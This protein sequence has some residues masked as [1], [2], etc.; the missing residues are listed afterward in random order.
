MAVGNYSY[1]ELLDQV[2]D[3]SR[4]SNITN[5]LTVRN[6]INRAARVVVSGVD[7]RGT[8]RNSALST[9][10]FD[11]IYQY[12]VP[13][14]IKG[15]AIIDIQPQVNRRSDFRLTLVDEAEFDLKK[16][17]R[18]DIVAI[19]RDELVNR[20]L[21][22]GN[23][24]DVTT[25]AATFDSL[26]ADGGTW[27]LFGD[28][29]NVTAEL[30]N[31]IAGSGSIEFDL[32]GSGTTAGISSTIT[33]IDVTDFVNAGHVFV[34]VYINSTTNLT[35]WILRIGSNAS[36]YFTQTVTTDH[37]S[38]SFVNGWNLLRFDFAS[39]TETGTVVRTAVVYAAIFMTKTSAKSD[40]GYRVDQMVLHTGEIHNL[41]YYS[42]FAWQNSSGTYLEDSTSDTDLLNAETDEIE[43]YVWR[44]KMELYRELRRSDLVTDA[45]E[46]Y[47]LWKANYQRQ[48][49]SERIHR[50]RF[51]Y[52]PTLYHRQF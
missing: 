22:S 15:D 40:D 9:D 43:G 48:N 12:Q 51:Y 28:A 19:G 27:V 17:V 36:N 35:N 29:T 26:T 5:V 23:V 33:A 41:V 50:E 44:S 10:L 2:V 25:V 20:L 32:V 3:P 46:E 24:V 6:F 52:Q 18:T 16:K 34:W 14:D 30:D 8:K 37:V 7:L 4:R 13:S 31:F 1:S 42:R 45:K 21:F 39:M 47:K 38:A 49:P 11:D